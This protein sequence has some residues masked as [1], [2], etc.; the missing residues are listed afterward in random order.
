MDKL[1]SCLVL[2]SEPDF[3]AVD[4]AGPLQIEGA[5]VARSVAELTAAL[6]PDRILVWRHGSAV[7]AD[8]WE[9]ISRFLDSGGSLLYLGGEPF[10]RPV[11]GAPGHRQVQPRN[12]AVLKT[13]RL[14]QCYRAACGDA[15]LRG[16]GGFAG[17]VRKLNPSAWAAVLEP[18]LTDTK[19]FPDEEGSPGARDAIV[20]PLAFVHRADDPQFPAAA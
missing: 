20:R 13:L 6:K 9:S 7:P 18:R 2:F 5:I 3:P 19:D 17:S 15:E 1:L 14:N 12:L 10:T 16:V 11:A 4:V 8:A